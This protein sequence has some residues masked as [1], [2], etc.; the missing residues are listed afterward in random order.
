MR[1]RV[2]VAAVV[3]MLVPACS[4]AT[5]GTGDSAE[6]NLPVSD[7]VHAL[8]AAD[9]GA[10][11]LGLHGAL[12]RSPDGVN[13]RELGLEGQDA[14]AL[15][16]AAEGQPLLVGGH[17]VLARSTDTGETFEML[18]PS[19]LPSLDIHALAQA[20]GEPRT[21]YAYVVGHGIYRSGDAGETWAP[22]APVGERLPG[23]LVAMAVDPNDPQIVLVG[24]GGHGV[25]RSTDGAASFTRST[26]W[27]TLGLAFGADGTV[28]A[29][30]Y[31]GVDVSE[32]G[33]RSWDNV[34]GTDGFD[35]Q[36]L[37]VALGPD[38]AW[39][40]LTEEPRVLYRGSDEDGGFEEV[41]R[42]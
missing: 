38:G 4:S 18:N 15:G 16:V 17:D 42:A 33:G 22:A 25:F 7:H 26:D 24:S 29:A 21:V 5:T 8:R 37:A 34:A 28:L 41:A 39:W 40:V 9:D 13:W 2:F 3:L 32:D 36:P 23:D 12:W 35:G 14:M 1:S 27:G 11:L 6:G 19:D 31:Q 10:L 20:P 30:T